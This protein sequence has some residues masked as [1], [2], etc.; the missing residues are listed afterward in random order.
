MTPIA[1]IGTGIVGHAIAGRLV[2]LGHT[3]SELPGPEL[4]AEAEHVA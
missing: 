2:E 4:K 1:V 3:L